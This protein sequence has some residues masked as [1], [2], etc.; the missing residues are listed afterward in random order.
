MPDGYQ[1]SPGQ[2]NPLRARVA[3]TPP[4]KTLSGTPIRDALTR[5]EGLLE[6]L[7]RAVAQLEDVLKPALAG[8]NESTAAVAQSSDFQSEL[9]ARIAAINDAILRQIHYVNSIGQRVQL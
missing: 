9:E 2:L 3:S 6:D 1:S 8:M 4:P 7:H 5:T